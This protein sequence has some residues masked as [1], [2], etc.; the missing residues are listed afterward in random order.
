[1]SIGKAARTSE[2]GHFAPP[3]GTRGFKRAAGATRRVGSLRG[4]SEPTQTHMAVPFSADTAT[5][6][7]RERKVGQFKVSSDAATHWTRVT[8]KAGA[9]DPPEVVTVCIIERVSENVGLCL[10]MIEYSMWIAE[11]LARAT[12]EDQESSACECG[13]RRKRAELLSKRD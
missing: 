4:A 8:H 9:I 10:A 1:M 7:V 11:R 13:A 2:L 6:E 5:H 3:G 12:D